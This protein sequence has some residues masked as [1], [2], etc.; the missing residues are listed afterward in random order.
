[1]YGVT[2]GIGELAEV[3]LSP[4]QTQQF[5]SGVMQFLSVSRVHGYAGL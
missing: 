4:E 1:M 5:Q 2:T 3:V